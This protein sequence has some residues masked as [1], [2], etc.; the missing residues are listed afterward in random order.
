MKF[1][2]APSLLQ[3]RSPLRAIALRRQPESPCVVDI[4]KS[5]E[6][7]HKGVETLPDAQNAI[8]FFDLAAVLQP[9]DR[10]VEDCR[11]VRRRLA[12]DIGYVVFSL[13]V[14]ELPVGISITIIAAR[15]A[16]LI[17]RAGCLVGHCVLSSLKT[18]QSPRATVNRRSRAS[19]RGLSQTPR[20]RPVDINPMHHNTF[21]TSGNQRVFRVAV[22]EHVSQSLIV[23]A[24]GFVCGFRS[25]GW[26]G[27]TRKPDR[28]IY[29]ARRF[30]G[31]SHVR[32]VLTTFSN[33]SSAILSRY[34]LGTS[35]PCGVWPITA[36]VAT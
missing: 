17:V 32:T 13:C 15:I 22:I 5:I 2:C 29:F 36:F 18:G 30:A 16:I 23:D 24:L 34:M 21:M 1:R 12:N 31:K 27:A 20:E 28:I 8:C 35:S 9:L 6:A 19:R 11:I 25:V 7:V 4:F 14:R 10:V 33:R 26:A 3:W